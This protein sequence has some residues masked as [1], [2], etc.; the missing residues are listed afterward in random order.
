M[1]TTDPV[2]RQRGHSTSINPLLSKN[3]SKKK[4]NIWLKIPDLTKKRQAGRLTVGG[5]IT[6]TLTGAWPSRVSC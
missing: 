4:E 6:S 5:N 1:K 2:F 3:N